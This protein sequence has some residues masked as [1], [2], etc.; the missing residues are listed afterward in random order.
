MSIGLKSKLGNE[1]LVKVSRMKPVIKPTVPHRHAGYHE[2]IYL[3]K[4]AGTHTIGDEK[5][6][7]IPNTGYYLG[8][9][10]IH[11]WDFSKIPDG[12]VILFKEEIL[13]AYPQ[14]LNS[15][16]QINK[17]F[18][19]GKHSELL[20]PLLENFH[21]AFKEG[22]KLEQLTAYLNLLILNSLHLT[23]ATP[24]IDST[25]ID[26]LAQFKRLINENFAQL[27]NVQEYADLM[28]VSVRKLN[29]ICKKTL[30]TNAREVIKQRILI[31]AKNLL[32]HTDRQVIEIAFD[33]NFTD[34]S[35]FVKFFKQQT[36]L[37][38]LEY[39]AKIKV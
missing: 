2:L 21:L 25:L 32:T 5:F 36:N 12:Y 20:F 19:L 30:N 13:A 27:K 4:G 10:E 26:Q 38:P 16:F 22:A 24:K 7:V 39:R 35:N 9:S 8:L 31:E 11:C 14:A 17:T 15:L 34:S 23:S 6:E 1:L 33:L 3:S 18:D 28:N 29:L 37:T